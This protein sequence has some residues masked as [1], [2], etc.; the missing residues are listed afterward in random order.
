M[1]KQLPILT[2]DPRHHPD[3]CLSLS[4]I[5]ITHLTSLFTTLLP[6][7]RGNPGPVRDGVKRTVLSIGSGT[8]LL[9]ALINQ[10]LSED[11][12]GALQN[13]QLGIGLNLL[14]VEGIEVHA[15]PPVNRY[16]EEWSCHE[17]KGTWDLC[18]MAGEDDVRAWMFVYPRD[19]GLVG[20]YVDMLPTES[21]EGRARSVEMIF[22]A[23]P[24]CDIEEYDGTW[25]RLE[26]GKWIREQKMGKEAGLKE[27][28]G[29]IVLRRHSKI[30]SI[31]S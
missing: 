26:E 4:T 5:L 18:E 29:I 7:H 2:R 19:V 20:R 25:K 1:P 3:C 22:W 17:V 12:F 15:T 24:R 21:G 16:L 11:A 31:D 27:W 30:S 10:S 8:G 14:H 13:A 23:G 6:P 9:E 28:E